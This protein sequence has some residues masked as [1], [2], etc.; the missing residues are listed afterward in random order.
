M[1]PPLIRG[2]PNP[3]DDCGPCPIGGLGDPERYPTSTLVRSIVPATNWM[4][5]RLPDGRVSGYGVVEVA[6]AVW[7]CIDCNE[8]LINIDR[9]NGRRLAR[10]V[11][12]WV[13]NT[14]WS[15]GNDCQLQQLWWSS[16]F[17]NKAMPHGLMP[18]RKQRRMFGVRSP[19]PKWVSC[20]KVCGMDNVIYLTLLWPRGGHSRT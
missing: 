11:Y 12:K 2:R 16:W 19:C 6:D 18:E 14:K 7:C 9:S 3:R 1:A 13:D 8:L 4:A 20:E 5:S 17:V 15:L 10:K